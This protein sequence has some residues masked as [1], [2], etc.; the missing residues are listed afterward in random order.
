MHVHEMTSALFI[1]TVLDFVVL[2][3]VFMCCLIISNIFHWL[4][5]FPYRSICS[6]YFSDTLYLTYFSILIDSE[7]S[8]VILF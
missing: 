8:V 7:E 4:L 3:K 5:F 2:T 1:L 6:V